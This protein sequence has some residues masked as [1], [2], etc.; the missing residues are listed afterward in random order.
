MLNV[1]ER[2]D[3]VLAA[4]IVV[5]QVEIGDETPYHFRVIFWQIYAFLLGL[6]V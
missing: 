6:L 5:A 4:R 2:V 3:V 1:V